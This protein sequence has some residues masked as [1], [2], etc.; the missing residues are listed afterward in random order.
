LLIPTVIK[1]GIVTPHMWVLGALS[2]VLTFLVPNSVIY[3]IPA[4]CICFVHWAVVPR[5]RETDLANEIKPLTRLGDWSYALY[6]CHVPI[7]LWMFRLAPSSWSG[8]L[9]WSSSI[10][11]SFIV[12]AGFG[13][14]DLAM[15]RR[16]KA[17]VD[18]SASAAIPV[19]RI[20]ALFATAFLLYGGIAEAQAWHD[21]GLSANANMIG[22]II[23]SSR[24]FT[25]IDF[26]GAA[27]RAH[28]LQDPELDGFVDEQVCSPDGSVQMRGWA[29]DRKGGSKGLAVLV[30]SNG[31]YVGNGITQLQRPDVVKA[32]KLNHFW[33][34][35]GF[36]VELSAHDCQSS[37]ARASFIVIKDDRY[38]QLQSDSHL[39][40][41]LKV[42][43]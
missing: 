4:A 41:C 3:A 43:K 2:V 15:Y 24:P 18:R 30:F 10:A 19:E 22:Q 33:Q 17:W 40:P 28:L 32:L 31:A 5:A 9:L 21:A 16:L 38:T 13:T 12:A 37:C 8:P 42:K 27:K 25:P 7:L 34:T 29:A 26:A 35:P 39:G 1:R 6:L 20:G 23:A 14:I 36:V 11:F